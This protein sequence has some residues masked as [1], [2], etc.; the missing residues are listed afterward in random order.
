MKFGNI[1][2]KKAEFIENANMNT[3]VKLGKPKRYC[4][5]IVPIDIEIERRLPKDTCL[6]RV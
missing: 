4:N 1:E 2:G 3:Q 6:L 5:H